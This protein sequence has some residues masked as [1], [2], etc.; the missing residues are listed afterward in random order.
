MQPRV[1]LAFS[2]FHSLASPYPPK[3]ECSPA[4]MAKVSNT[5]QIRKPVPLDQKKYP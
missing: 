1:I 4:A 3:K 2:L 5:S